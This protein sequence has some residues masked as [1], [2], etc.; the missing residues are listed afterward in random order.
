MRFRQST[1]LEGRLAMLTFAGVFFALPGSAQEV[2]PP[3]RAAIPAEVTVTGSRIWRQ[4]SRYSALPNVSSRGRT[5]WAGWR[6]RTRRFL[7]LRKPW[8]L[9]RRFRQSDCGPRLCRGRGQCRR[10]RRILQLRPLG[11]PR[12]ASKDG[13]HVARGD[14]AHTLRAG[15][16]AD[17]ARPVFHEPH[18]DSE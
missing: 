2:P 11:V 13:S 18:T 15:R 17:N 6:L 16:N 10:H 12:S 5:C 9:P 7:E 4:S 3:N 1:W 14:V 8:H